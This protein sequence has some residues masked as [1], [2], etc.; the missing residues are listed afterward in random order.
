MNDQFEIFKR[1]REY[2]AE[3]PE[4]VRLG[5][6]NILQ[7]DFKKED[8]AVTA[9]QLEQLQELEIIPPPSIYT[10]IEQRAITAYQL[11][12]LKN[13]QLAPPANAYASILEKIEAEKNLKRIGGGAIVRT[14]YRFRA[15]IAIILLVGTGWF[16]YRL[17]TSPVQPVIETVT[18]TTKPA[19]IIKD[20]VQNKDFNEI[21]KSIAATP[22]K[23]A[24]HKKQEAEVKEEQVDMSVDEYKFSVKNN[25]LMA[26]FASFEYQHLPPF[27]TGPEDKAFT[28]RVDQYAA[29]SVSQPMSKMIRKMNQYRRNGK[30]KAR[31]RKTRERLEKWKAADAGQFDKSLIKNPLD[32]L[33][34]AEFIFN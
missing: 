29:I 24:L 20:T 31:A 4:K 19:E 10:I 30:L 7:A 21:N 27:L 5:I 2:E 3:P 15:A 16:T 1:L 18:N 25:D 12:F 11:S 8:V 33:D 9:A 34:L 17:A 26:A 23:K 22:V 32:P 13:Y 28:I 6:F 14:L